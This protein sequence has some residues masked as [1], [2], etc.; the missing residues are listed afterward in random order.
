[1][2]QRK[3][4]AENY[5]LNFKTKVISEIEFGKYATAEE[6]RKKYGIGGKMTVYRWLKDFKKENLIN[7][8]VFL[9]KN[10]KTKEEQTLKK[11][12]KALEKALREEQIKT[13]V[14][15]TL[16]KQANRYYD[17]DLKKNFG[18]LVQKS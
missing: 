17:T 4:N 13:L 9:Q 12:V 18:E 6:A 5:S 2:G 8:E 7:K 15:E 14:L 3:K 16:V 11:Q 1:M 10:E